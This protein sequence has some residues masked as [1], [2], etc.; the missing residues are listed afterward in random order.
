MPGDVAAAA[1][2]VMPAA[3]LDL[4]GRHHRG[5]HERPGDADVV[6]A[7]VARPVRTFRLWC[8]ASGTLNDGRDRR[9]RFRHHGD[10]RIV[11]RPAAARAVAVHLKNATVGEVGGMR[12]E[13]PRAAAIATRRMRRPPGEPNRAPQRASSLPEGARNLEQAG[14]AGAVVAHPHLPAVVVSMQKQ[15]AVG[16]DRTFYVHH[17][18][19][20]WEPPLLE[21][22]AD[23]RHLTFLGCGKH[24]GA[25]AAIYA[26]RWDLRQLRHGLDAWRA[27][28]GRGG[29]PMN[30]LAGID[31]DDAL[32]SHLLDL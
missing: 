10:G 12:V 31:G 8:L 30:S 25:V 26:G 21:L 14:V 3:L 16:L 4:G 24:D 17:R 2:D 27:P 5:C 15:E 19:L 6:K 13:I 22:G 23:G 7:I 28:D 11:R 1:S 32:G 18:Q 20:L 29:G 9:H